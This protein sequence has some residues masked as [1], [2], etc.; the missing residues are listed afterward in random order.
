MLE[1]R[2]YHSLG[3]VGRGVAEKVRRVQNRNVST[4]YMRFNG[5]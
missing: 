3:G 5:I 4:V 1:N 2:K